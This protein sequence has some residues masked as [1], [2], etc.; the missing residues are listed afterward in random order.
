MTKEDDRVL[1][2]E[3][4]APHGLR[5]EVRAKSHTQDPLE[6][7]GYGPLFDETGR[8]F[9]VLSV[10]PAKNVVVL[11]LEG[12]S[13]REA[14]EALKGKALYIAREQLP[15]DGLEEDEVFQTDLVG[16]S[17]FDQA[18]AAYGTVAS[19]HNFGAGDILELVHAGE[20]SV[21]IPFS[22]AAVRDIDWNVGRLIVDPVAAGL[23]DEGED[24]GPGSRRRRPPAQR[25]AGSKKGGP[26]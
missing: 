20:R 13:S 10:R 6:L 23:E 14:A 19:V 18:G 15:D 17:V 22:E 9:H 26:S 4:G 16:L 1:M 12:V 7:G 2:A 21:M 25:P 3:I 8:A 24:D 5:G 11:K